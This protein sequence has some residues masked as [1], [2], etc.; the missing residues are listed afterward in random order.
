MDKVIIYCCILWT[1]LGKYGAVAHPIIDTDSFLEETCPPCPNEIPICDNV[2][3][4]VERGSGLPSSCCPRYECRD[5]EPVCDGSKMR[6][7]KNKCTVCDPCEPLAVQCKEMCAVEE[8]IPICLTDNNEYKELGD[9]WKENNGCT[10]A[11]CLAGYVSRES[12]QCN[13]NYPCSNP[14]AIRGVCCL[15]CPEELDEGGSYNGHMP[16]DETTQGPEIVD[17][18]GSSEEITIKYINSTTSPE[19]STPNLEATESSSA[20][21]SS[22]IPTES[23]TLVT[24]ASEI[25]T[26]TPITSESTSIGVI[27][28]DSSSE[29]L[30]VIVSSESPDLKYPEVEE[31]T[32]SSDSP[33]ETTTSPTTTDDIETFKGSSTSPE[34]Y[35]DDG[36]T[37]IDL[38]SEKTAE[39]SIDI[40]TETAKINFSVITDGPMT[41]QPEALAP[42]S[43]SQVKDPNDSEVHRRSNPNYVDVPQ[44]KIKNDYT[45]V[46]GGAAVGVLVVII[47]AIW[48]YRR[49]CSI[50]K[51]QIVP[52]R[53]LSSYV[54]VKCNDTKENEAK[55]VIPAQ[56]N[57]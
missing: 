14:I 4:E 28:T 19:T 25:F 20:V 40:S 46:S 13:H 34:T 16:F 5:E 42:E 6:F 1:G 23:S 45:W 55:L 7:Y 56:T 57:S 43:T 21:N 53:E 51:Y 26:T 18:D 48:L 37:N 31:G 17:D 41:N 54:N 38:S 10:T 47:T 9:V 49:Y 2:I 30:E 8:E 39:D 32:S 35:T 52:G 11:T 12:V 27:T 15:V 36:I 50:K 22:T 24:E 44:E 33:T 29:T 3:V